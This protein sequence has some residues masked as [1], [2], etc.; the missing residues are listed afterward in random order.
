[1]PPQ[2]AGFIGLGQEAFDSPDKNRW[3]GVSL[4][5]FLD[6]TELQIANG[7]DPKTQTPNAK[8]Q[9]D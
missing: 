7:G 1:V 6:R 9:T 4:T 8:P 5:L 3:D 2:N